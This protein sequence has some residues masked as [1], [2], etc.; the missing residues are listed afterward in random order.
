MADIVKIFHDIGTI[1]QSDVVRNYN[2]THSKNIEKIVTLEVKGNTIQEYDRNA[3]VERFFLR[4]TSSNGG[5]LFPFL[6]LSDKLIDGLHKAFKNMRRHISKEH[7]ETLE[8][9]EKELDI[10]R[11]I[12]IM[13]P[14]QGEK[15]LYLGLLYNGQS[16]NELFPEIVTNY[17]SSVCKSDITKKADCYI[18]GMSTI[19]FDAGLNF[20]SVNELPSK[21]KKSTKYRLLPLSKEASC[22]I[23]QGFEKVFNESIFRFRLFGLG[24]YLLPSILSTDKRKIIEYI[25]KQSKESDDGIKDKFRLEK[26]L[27]QLCKKLESDAEN[28]AVLFTFLF[29]NKSNSAIDLY[30]SIEDVA[31]SRITRAQTLMDQFKIAPENLSKYTKKTDF[32]AAA[33]YIRDY[34]AEPLMLAKLIFGKERISHESH[35]LR[36]IST[37]ILYGNNQPNNEKRSYSNI[38][39]GYY[40][41]DTDFANHQ[42]FIH[43][44]TA[45]NVLGFNAATLLQ[46]EEK[47]DTFDSFRAQT[48]AK[49]DSVELLQNLRAREFYIVGA[50]AQLVISWQYSK[51]S[52]TVAKYIDSIG[53]ISMQNIERV[54]RKVI[55][56]A[57]KYSM[58]GKEFDALL[59]L[60]SDIHSQLKSSHLLSVDK[61]NIAF[62]MGSIDY[63]NYKAAHKPQKEGEAQ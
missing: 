28:S 33:I 47:M 45:L 1:Y 18:N 20:C 5:N 27:V 61:G 63:K 6:F 42:R 10:E 13:Q 57:K 7:I 56:G 12:E 52:D 9:I 46:G 15:N 53:T 14:F 44:L 55:D 23:Q 16:F 25:A 26:R 29:A 36:L 3:I 50:L 49:F 48:Q 31:P 32:D 60:Y 37:K 43:F 8:T 11:I 40:S 30:Q 51:E 59:T 34:I 58:G 35:L 38:I 2:E 4:V 39:N 21:L 17:I 24:Y 19:G 41:S 54:F 62:V 22:L